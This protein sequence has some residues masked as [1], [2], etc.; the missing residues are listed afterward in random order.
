MSNQLRIGVGAMALILVGLLWRD[1]RPASPVE[2]RGTGD[3]V[4]IAAT[5][6]TLLLKPLPS[7]NSD[8][9][10][11]D[12]EN[13]LQDAS[14][15]VTNLEENLLDPKNIP[16]GASPNE[17]RWPFGTKKSA[18]DLRRL[19]FT[20]LSLANNHAIDYGVDAISRTT[21]ILDGAGLLHAGTGV[22]SAQARA[23][24]SIGPAGR[25]VAL[26]AVAASA[27]PEARATPT[28]GEILG[29]PGVNAL[30]YAPDVT[31][32][33]QTF[34]TLKQSPAAAAPSDAKSSELTM[35]GRVIKKGART[36]VHFVADDQDSNEILTQVRTARRQAEI[37]IVMV[38]SHEP[39]NQS[40]EP[41]DFF[42]KF[43]RDTIEAGAALVIGQGPHQLR[44]IEVYK[45][46]VIF[47]SLGNFIFDLT[48]VDPRSEDVFDA[49]T[50]LYRL[51]LGAVSDQEAPTSQA[52]ENPASWESVIALAEFER[53]TLR[54]VRLQPLDLGVDLPAKQRGTPHLANADRSRE[55]LRR[56][57]DLSREFGTRVRIENSIGV[58]DRE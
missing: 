28:R 50:D 9:G 37:V 33:A 58:I 12:V 40:T 41:A 38:H 45:T 17:R 23:P 32:D 49:G 16:G 35:S 5:G 31:V 19:G 43:A 46:G 7:V 4:T 8:A 53:G 39:S 15:A 2:L 26:I 20:I 13:V 30:K 25:H 21:Q 57:S 24:A 48:S 18:Q 22:D 55:I 1:L 51:A 47:Y 3:S 52:V 27:S 34:A 14:L 54:S 42:R 10:L 11:R 36:D 56:L 44:G 6:D 29:R